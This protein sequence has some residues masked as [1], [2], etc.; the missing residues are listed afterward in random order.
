M[1]VS[2]GLAMRERI[3]VWLYAAMLARTDKYAY[4][5]GLLESP[6]PLSFCFAHSSGFR[7]YAG[8]GYSKTIDI[9]SR[10]Q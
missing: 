5:I 10:D 1:T 2:A 9:T 6:P 3:V 4:D 8:S 7:E